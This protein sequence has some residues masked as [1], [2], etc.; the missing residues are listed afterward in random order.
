MPGN[1]W[2]AANRVR[3]PASSSGQDGLHQGSADHI[4]AFDAS[5]CCTRPKKEPVPAEV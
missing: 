4:E 1:E 2:V 5:P 3:F